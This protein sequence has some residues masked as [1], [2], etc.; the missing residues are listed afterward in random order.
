MKTRMHKKT[1]LNNNAYQIDG[2]SFMNEVD[3]KNF[4]GHAC[5]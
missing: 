2:I 3:C 1:N 5:G 4:I